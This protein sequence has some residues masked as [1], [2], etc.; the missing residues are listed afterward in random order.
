MKTSLYSDD[1]DGLDRIQA[2]GVYK[3]RCFAKME[4]KSHDKNKI[5]KS[6]VVF[7]R[8]IFLFTKEY[9]Y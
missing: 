2:N 1:W 5:I 7:I 4:A 3:F 9:C 8:F 6:V